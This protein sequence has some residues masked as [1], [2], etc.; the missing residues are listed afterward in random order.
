MRKLLLTGFATILV[1]LLTAC[2]Q[3]APTTDSTPPNTQTADHAAEKAVR[4][5]EAMQSHTSEP[6]SEGGTKELEMTLSINGQEVTVDWESNES[7]ATLAAYAANEEIIVQTTLYGGFEQVG[8]LPQ[9]FVSSDVQMITQP[10][11][12]ILYSGD[13]IVLFFGSNSWSYTKLGHIENLSADEL[14]ELLGERTVEVT[15]TFNE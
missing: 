6:V 14:S 15:L 12:I 5:E 4:T 10:G 8:S 7:V 1:A 3:Q 11:D 9:S 13:Q 2:S